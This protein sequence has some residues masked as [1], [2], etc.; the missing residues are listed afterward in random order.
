MLLAIALQIFG[1]VMAAIV[2]T[3]YF[4]WRAGLAVVA[5]VTFAAGYA[6][7]RGTR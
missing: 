4:D 3:A 6:H 5:L 1:A 2:A 7:E